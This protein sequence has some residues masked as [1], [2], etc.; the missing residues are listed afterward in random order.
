M[1]TGITCKLAITIAFTIGLLASFIM[2]S[3]M[4]KRREKFTFSKALDVL[5]DATII[6]IEITFLGFLVA[7]LFV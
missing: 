1:I 7:T 4:C 3:A 2:F 5:F 6:A